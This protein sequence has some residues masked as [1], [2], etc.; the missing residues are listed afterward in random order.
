MQFI[1]EKST[2]SQ[3][4][5]EGANLWLNKNICNVPTSLCNA[6]DLILRLIVAISII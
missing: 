5:I 3:T 4:R 2:Q 1:R 6:G